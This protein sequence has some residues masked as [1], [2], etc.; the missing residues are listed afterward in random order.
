MPNGVRADDVLTADAVEFPDRPAARSSAR[1]ARSCSRRG[2]PGRSDCETA[3]SR[4]SCRDGEGVREGDWRVAPVP[5][6]S[7]GPPG[8]DHRAGRPEDGDQRAQLGREDVHGRLRGLELAD[9]AELHR[10][11]GQPDRRARA[12]DLP[13][14]R[15][16]AVQP[17]RRDRDT[18]RAPAR[19]APR[20][21]AFR[22][23]RRPDLGEPVRLRPLLLPQPRPRRPLRSTCRS[24]SRT[25]RRGSG[26]T[27]SSGRRTSSACRAGPS[28][29]PS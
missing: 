5:G 3:S 25:W 1:A 15:R 13:G 14:Y 12:D 27:S 24:S 4:T 19:L 22:G 8:R 7:A 29:R 17:E 11:P 23:R 28:R 26:T 18:A 10:R 20:G 6:G 2:R 16:E 21:A 9:V